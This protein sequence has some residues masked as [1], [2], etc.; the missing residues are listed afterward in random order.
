MS[1]RVK[2]FLIQNLPLFCLTFYQQFSISAY[3]DFL[4]LVLTIN[5]Y[6]D[7]Q[8]YSLLKCLFLC[9]SLIVKCVHFRID[10]IFFSH[11]TSVAMHSC[12]YFFIFKTTC[13]DSVALMLSILLLYPIFRPCVPLQSKS[14]CGQTGKIS[15]S[16]VNLSAFALWVWLI[17]VR[18]WMSQSC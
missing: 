12:V 18:D 17:P 9:D 13:F 4:K 5:L 8:L 16:L 15:A 14:H 2:S 1:R 10:A 3:K 6:L 7:Y 11:C